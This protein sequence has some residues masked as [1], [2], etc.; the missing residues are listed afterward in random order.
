MDIPVN[1]WSNGK[2]YKANDI[3]RVGN[4]AVPEEGGARD[5]SGS[6]V[7]PIITE[8]S[9]EITEESE[10]ILSI[11]ITEES[12][13][14]NNQEVRV[15]GMFAVDPTLN[16]SVR[17]MVKKGTLTSQT[18][19][20]FKTLIKQKLENGTY[21][22][23]P[24][25][26]IGVGVGMKFYDSSGSDVGAPDLRDT[27][28]LM[29]SSE[30]S[31]AEYYNV[32]LDIDNKSIPDT[33][34][35]GS[36]VVFV[37]GIKSGSFVFK[38]LWAS[39]MSRFFYC[40]KDHTSS[41]GNEP[42]TLNSSTYWTQDFAWRPAYNSKA[43]FAAIN[44]KLK[45]GEGSDYVTNL[46]INSLPMQLTLAFDNKTDKE[47]R[48]IVHFLQEKFFPY[49]SIF[50]L[51]Y[52]G[53][54]LLS[55]DVGSFSFKYTYPYREDLKFT[56][57]DFSHTKKYRNNNQVQATFV[58]NTESTL[59]NVESH[60]GYNARLDALIPIF[61]DKTTK[62]K[63]GVPIRLNTFSLE[64]TATGGGGGGGGLDPV[65]A[66]TLLTDLI[67]ISKYPEEQGEPIAGGLLSFSA[68]QDL[69]VGD[70]I[71]IDIPDDLNSIFDVGQTKIT[72]KLSDTEFVFL[73]IKASGSEV[74]VG[75]RD[76][77]GIE[78]GDLI[79]PDQ[80]ETALAV[81][82]TTTENPAVVKKLLRCPDECLTSS[83]LMPPGVTEILA[84]PTNPVTGETYPRIVYTKQYRKLQL[85]SD[86]RWDNEEASGPWQPDTPY[87]VGDVVSYNGA[88]Y[89]STETHTSGT[90]F[91]T[92][93]WKEATRTGT[94]TVTPL[95][96]FTLE[97]TDDFQLL[98]PSLRGRHSI[99]I[100]NPDEFIKY[101]WIEVRNFDHKPSIAFTINDAP[102]HISSKFVSYYNH[103]FKKEINQ[104]LSTFSVVF[105]KRSDDEAAE[106]LQFLESQ[107]GY[108]KFRFQMPRPYVKD[109]NN[110]TTQSRPYT[111]TFFCPSWGH[112]VIYKNNHTITATFIESATSKEEDLR[113]VFGIGRKEESPCFGAQIFDPITQHGLCTFSSA[114]QIAPGKGLGTLPGG[115]L[116]KS[117][118]NKSVDIVF[119]IDGSG[120][121]SNI[122][123]AEGEDET[124]WSV[125]IDVIQ[126]IIVSYNTS[127]DKYIM[128]GTLGWNGVYKT[129]AMSHSSISGD[130]NVPP[131]PVRLSDPQVSASDIN[132]YKSLVS[133]LYDPNEELNSQMQVAGYNLENLDKFTI[134][135]D[136][137][138]VNLG[139]NRMTNGD[140]Y[141]DI[142]DTPISFDKL[143]MFK[144]LRDNKSYNGRET[145]G[146]EDLPYG[147]SQALAQLYNSPR[148]EYVTDRIIIGLSDFVL[149][150][151]TASI[152]GSPG[153]VSSRGIRCFW[154]RFD[155]TAFAMTQ[156]MKTG[157][158]LAK[159]RPTDAVLK[160]YGG[161]RNP[162]SQMQAYSSQTGSDGN[163]KLINADNGSS[164]PAW[165]NDEIP[166]IFIPATVGV[167]G[168]ISKW[169]PMYAYDY[170]KGSPLAEP[171]ASRNDLLDP[172]PQFYFPITNSGITGGELQRMMELIL[173]LEKITKDSGYQNIFSITVHNC[174]PHA[175]T[176]LNSLIN[177]E[178]QSN[179]LT[180]T[181]E[182]LPQGIPKGGNIT[183]LKFSNSSEGISSIRNGYGGQ[184][185]G[186][187]RNQ[188]LFSEQDA[189]SNILWE[190]FNTQYEVY[191]AG[192]V[193]EIEG[194]WSDH[195]GETR[196]VGN[197]GVAFKGM[198]VRV[199]K[200][201]AGLEIVDYNIGKVDASNNYK[202]DY[203]HLP[204]LQPGEQIDLFFGVK[205]G[206]L[207][208]ITEKIQ[209]LINS[210]DGTQKKMDC[211]G[212]FEFTA[213][214]LPL[215]EVQ[216]TTS[217]RQPI[218]SDPVT[219]DPVTP[220]PVE[221]PIAPI[222][223]DEQKCKDRFVLKSK[224]FSE[225]EMDTS[226]MFSM[227]PGYRS[228]PM[229]KPYQGLGSTGW[230]VFDTVE[231]Q[232]LDW[233]IVLSE[234][235]Y[236]DLKKGSGTSQPVGSRIW[237]EMEAAMGSLP[238]TYGLGLN[239]QGIDAGLKKWPE[240]EVEYSY[241]GNI[242]YDPTSP[243]G[244]GVFV[245]VASVDGVML[246]WYRSTN[247][248]FFNT[249]SECIYFPAEADGSAPSNA[250]IFLD[251]VRQLCTQ[252]PPASSSTCGEWTRKSIP[253]PD[254]GWN[255]DANINLLVYTD[256]AYTP[257]GGSIE[258]I[259][260]IAPFMVNG[261]TLPVYDD[262]T[263]GDTWVQI[264]G[265]VDG[266]GNSCYLTAEG[267]KGEIFHA[268]LSAI[269]YGYSPTFEAAYKLW[270]ENCGA[271]GFNPLNNPSTSSTPL[272]T[273][274]SAPATSVNPTPVDPCPGFSCLR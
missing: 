197:T 30:L 241:Q 87:S 9:Q 254:P 39:N 74:A 121:M 263:A 220:D 131:W 271:D 134:P 229:Q 38:Q 191:R 221:T 104:N 188:N 53:N 3:V 238:A 259:I 171:E 60:A 178:G 58:C 8:Q 70:C 55:S 117:V 147:L 99:Y 41:P 123:R 49:E 93:K 180:W 233:A 160:G 267:G 154:D 215:N 196:G 260:P 69:S 224:D 264:P 29:A 262:P 146:R 190:S 198:P 16:Y 124:K 94:I 187:L 159:R 246:N 89:K 88:N 239:Q 141:F 200:S 156:A 73:P 17:G 46:A 96:D 168:R 228:N 223:S 7:V 40:V 86:I 34:V 268:L 151:N 140:V 50:A 176:L 222:D 14:S 56:C 115:G 127:V 145:G 270:L 5:S 204:K 266:G 256:L 211:F 209:I 28:R 44:D 119:T 248:L 37:Y 120:S 265:V 210:D 19:D 237:L 101:P 77:L 182:T 114:L 42:N 195:N 75:A 167:E 78:D 236:G 157:G 252:S 250:K 240:A 261:Y 47:A 106:I 170:D 52:K 64:T 103:E 161:G 205:I 132:N 245:K 225:V 15:G 186:D 163:S 107:L 164:N 143:R 126:K 194:G 13:L 253:Y 165:Y 174:G 45:M 183:D 193:S 234:A 227:M 130:T 150:E 274:T 177:V 155:P 235:G 91:D 85:D 213:S 139:L 92:S 122:L 90:S 82:S 153:C 181:T 12:A 202:G 100:R 18:V 110:L 129:P 189:A 125:A 148:A 162:Y 273:I 43:T 173:L 201:N 128:P 59:R 24:Q 31:D 258:T 111:S 255:T 63:K 35:T 48:A 166:T 76:P 199:F 251:I 57:T 23:D 218:T 10:A 272:G 67:E 116:G 108:K 4:F 185:Y 36:M 32:Q 269:P 2:K 79:S 20:P 226:P 95:E 175:V 98:L 54:R 97:S 172:L 112:Q 144:K 66:A 81:S 133:E 51:D 6:P 212:H 216:G 232:K 11:E 84:R 206:R 179:P 137:K 242:A 207:A 249:V 217:M 138:R 105:D 102:T 231:N 1:R 208:D 247:G 244:T 203:T 136:Q 26:S 219:P 118:K 83:I 71:N 27:H 142:S 230:Y 158:A 149:T 25:N 113:D 80:S 192:V 33:A 65:P 152:L 169:A 243:V 62:F 109:E 22:V 135:I 61:L 72:Q 21:I 214:G 68:S 184:Y 257:A